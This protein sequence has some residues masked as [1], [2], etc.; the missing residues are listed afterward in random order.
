LELISR[1]IKKSY[2][3]FKS[4]KF[5]WLFGIPFVGFWSLYFLKYVA[6]H[7]IVFGNVY[8]RT[9]LA[10]LL[11]FGAAFAGAWFRSALIWTVFR[12]EG[13]QEVSLM[14]ALK[15]ST[16]HIGTV[17]LSGAIVS[18]VMFL[19]VMW[20][21]VPILLVFNRDLIFRAVLLGLVGLIIF[22]PVAITLSLVHI[23]TSCFRVIYGMKLKQ[24]MQS[25]FDLL[26]SCWTSALHLYIGLGVVYVLLLSLSASALS[27]GGAIG[28]VI[29]RVLG[30]LSLAAFFGIMVLFSIGLGLL[31][32]AC[33]ALLNSFANISW[34]LFFLEHVNS[35]NK[36]EESKSKVSVL[37]RL[38]E[39]SAVTSSIKGG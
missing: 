7:Q 33:N 21:S 11:V 32:L 6:D 37:S 31:L 3:Y 12:L 2:S 35:Q 22:L 29:A 10:A 8:I 27:A 26:G 4:H 18:L 19:V 20:V 36:T 34:T 39:D 30:S 1:I 9:G 5:L 28:F 38:A 13:N 14:T 17:L 15:Q 25:A 24:A 16:K 23:F